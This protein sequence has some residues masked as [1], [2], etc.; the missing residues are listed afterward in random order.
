MN[1]EKK[2]SRLSPTR[3]APKPGHKHPIGMAEREAAFGLYRDM[4]VGRTYEKLRVAF[5]KRHVAVTTR[6]LAN[7]AKAHHWRKRVDEHD[8]AIVR[9]PSTAL[10]TDPGFDQVDTLLRTAH[11]ALQRVLASTPIVMRASD[12]K[13]L[14]DAALGALKV[15]ELIKAREA[16]KAPRGKEKTEMFRLLNTIETRVRAADAEAARVTAIAKAVGLEIPRADW[17]IVVSLSDDRPEK[18]ANGHSSNDL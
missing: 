4:G 14:T 2:G 1:T 16:E 12:A 10:K 17:E 5:A 11:L 18:G 3:R 8:M 15:V 13:A 9:M 7:W 6:T